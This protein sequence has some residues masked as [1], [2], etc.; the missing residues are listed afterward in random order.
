MTNG[1][2]ALDTR[3]HC[4]V[5]HIGDFEAVAA[6]DD[7]HRNLVTATFAA[8][9]DASDCGDEIFGHRSRF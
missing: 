4:A 8:A 7:S 3:D 9:F 6:K 5:D 1:F 2:S